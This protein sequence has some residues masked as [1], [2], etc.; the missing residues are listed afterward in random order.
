MKKFSGIIC[1]VL[2]FAFIMPTPISADNVSPINSAFDTDVA[3]FCPY[4]DSGRY[5]ELGQNIAA[6][7]G[8]VCDIFT[9]A[10]AT[11]E[12]LKNADAYGVIIIDAPTVELDGS[13]YLLFQSDEGISE[14]DFLED[15]AVTLT[16]AF[17]IT[18]AFLE[19]Y[20]IRFPNSL[21]WLSADHGMSNDSLCASLLSLGCGVVTGYSSSATV[22]WWNDFS[23]AF[24]NAMILGSNVADSFIF[25]CD[26]IGSSDTFLSDIAYAI[27]VST[28][29]VFPDDPNEENIP[30]CDWQ[31]PVEGEIET[32]APSAVTLT[33]DYTE[34]YIGENIRLLPEI[35]PLNA[36]GF[37]VDFDS[38]DLAVATVDEYGYV[39][40]VSKGSA[41]IT[42]TVWGTHNG[43]NYSLEA[44]TQ[45]R[46]VT[47]S[48]TC[49][50]RVSYPVT[51]ESYLIVCASEGKAMGNSNP[52]G[53]ERY[54]NAVNI[55]IRG[56]FC[57]VSEDAASLWRFDADNDG[58][59]ISCDRG[60]LTIDSAEYL[61]ISDSPAVF[62]YADG[63]LTQSVSSDYS[64]VCYADGSD[65]LPSRFTTI[66]SR[67]N[68]IA[69]YRVF[70]GFL[71]GDVDDNGV[72]T[73]ADA[74][75]ILRIAM[76]IIQ[77]TDDQQLLGDFDGSGII[78]AID[79]LELLRSV[80]K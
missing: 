38:S 10:S 8:G 76:G 56:N 45:V 16:D 42:C 78:T 9:G 27:C 28:S 18:G 70:E 25:A 79:A 30:T 3:V 53:F 43:E 13:T 74:L 34:L 50:E 22:E 41:E 48:V 80:L 60:Y 33:P 51:G 14:A 40:A 6:A 21:V 15:R 49:Y 66:G 54:V 2:V 57:F 37:S 44:R 73:T 46:V 12:T 29:D 75:I 7:T 72:L 31:L 4:G 39:T 23:A 47:P 32:V 58:F 63:E 52:T 62:Q 17:G 67:G 24:F 5:A 65:S 68:F 36:Y 20:C 35:L 26:T 71:L 55:T 1:F 59:I 61:N 64:Y 11:P 77:P 69:L 19:N